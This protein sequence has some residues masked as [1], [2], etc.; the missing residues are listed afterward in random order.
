LTSGAEPHAAD[1]LAR[2]RAGDR[3]AIAALIRDIDDGRPGVT[4]ELAGLSLDGGPEWKLIV[5]ITGAPGAGK[6]TLVDALVGVWRAR[7]LRVGVLTVDPSSPRHGGAILGDRIRMQRH[8]TDDGVFIRS[9]GTRGASGGL[10]QA[11]RA[12][13]RVLMAGGF[14]RVLVETV[15]VG[16][17]EVDITRAAAVT[18]VVTVPGLGDDIQTMK[19]GVFEVADV[20]V[21]NKGDRAGAD[22]TVRDLQAMLSLRQAAGDEAAA[23]VPVLTTVATTGVGVVELD[24]AIEQVLIGKALAAGIG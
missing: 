18:V 11:T 3:R 7:G 16:Q 6:S 23:Q 10:S 19:A 5:G 12:A 13:A 21:V 22:Q 14:P 2:V 24:A 9:F 1:R 20:L 8:A 17:S 4:D 15:G